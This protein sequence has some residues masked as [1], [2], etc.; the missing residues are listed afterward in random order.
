[1]IRLDSEAFD[2]V[3]GTNSG[4][5]NTVGIS[6]RCTQL[7]KSIYSCSGEIALPGWKDTFQRGCG[8]Q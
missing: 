8:N 5:K 4:E 2:R 6:R 7:P 3:K 1:M